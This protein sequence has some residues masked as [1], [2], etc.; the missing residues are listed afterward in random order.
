MQT[1][2]YIHT[3]NNNSSVGSSGDKYFQYGEVYYKN[4]DYKNAVSCYRTAAD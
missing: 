2:V 1:Q 4:K 3:S